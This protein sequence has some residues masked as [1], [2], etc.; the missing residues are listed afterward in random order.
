ML[1][2][3]LELVIHWILK[4]FLL[5]QMSSVLSY[6]WETAVGCKL[7]FIPYFIM[8]DTSLVKVNLFVLIMQS[9][10]QIDMKCI[11]KGWTEWGIIHNKK[12][13]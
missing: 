12:T 4:C 6:F 5:M 3:H 8:L 2:I 9:T 1:H 7:V 11:W 10:I 13:G